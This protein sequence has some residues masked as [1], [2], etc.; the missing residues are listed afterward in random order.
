M[1]WYDQE[2]LD[3]DHREMWQEIERAEVNFSS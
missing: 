1:N 3:A 2:K